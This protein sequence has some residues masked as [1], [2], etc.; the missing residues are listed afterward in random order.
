MSKTDSAVE[1]RVLATFVIKAQPEAD[2]EEVARLQAS[3][4]DV[5]RSTPSIGEIELSSWMNEDGDVLQLYTFKSMDAMEA[6]VQ[7][8]EH[9]TIMKRG[10][11]FFASVKVQIASLEREREVTFNL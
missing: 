2:M 8:P 6:F 5:A 4:F 7:H 10:C 11:E 3:L 9:Q 1:T